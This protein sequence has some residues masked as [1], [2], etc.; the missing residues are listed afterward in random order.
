MHPAFS[1]KR[2][3]IYFLAHQLIVQGNLGTT[4]SICAFKND[5]TTAD[6]I[7]KRPPFQQQS[8]DNKECQNAANAN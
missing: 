7:Q 5:G 4:R 3:N 1:L 2:D 8:G 6:N